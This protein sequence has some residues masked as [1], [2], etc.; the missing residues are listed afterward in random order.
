L[1][2]S[3][4]AEPLSSQAAAAAAGAGR[5]CTL[6]AAATTGFGAR[7]LNSLV[8]SGCRFKTVAAA[9]AGFGRRSMSWLV[10]AAAV[11]GLYKLA[12]MLNGA[13]FGMALSKLTS[14][15]AA[16]VAPEGVALG[17]E[18]PGSVVAAGAAPAAPTA[19]ELVFAFRG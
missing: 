18:C 16:G 3:V 1:A 6:L 5:R 13:G 10:A 19:A 15:G 9:A 8:K 11:T 2:L 7:S 17:S 4:G 14:G 12:I